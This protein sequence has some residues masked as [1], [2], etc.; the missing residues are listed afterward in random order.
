[1]LLALLVSKKPPYA[2][3]QSI[4]VFS[5]LDENKENPSQTPPERK[6]TKRG[7]LPEGGRRFFLFNFSPLATLLRHPSSRHATLDA[8]AGRRRSEGTH[9]HL[10]IH[11]TRVVHVKLALLHG[12]VL[13]HILAPQHQRLHAK[14]FPAEGDERVDKHVPDVGHYVAGV[15]RST[16]SKRG[17]VRVY[18]GRKV[19]WGEVGWMYDLAIQ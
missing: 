10:Y 18:E 12:P 5:L 2:V 19:G 15:T 6:K 1:M 14:V 13:H 3:C 8:R 11:L 17:T 4:A 16:H 9:L 7:T